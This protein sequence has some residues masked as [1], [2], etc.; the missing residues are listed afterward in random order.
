MDFLKILT[1]PH[2]LAVALLTLFQPKVSKAVIRI[3]KPIY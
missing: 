3:R 1:T 2:P